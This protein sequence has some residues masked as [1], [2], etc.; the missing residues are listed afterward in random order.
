MKN[1]RSYLTSAALILLTFQ[2]F[3]QPA[4][5]K[6]SSENIETLRI[7]RIPNITSAAECYFSP[8]N[9]TLIY[10]GKEQGDSN[11][12]VY[13]INIDGTN[14]KKINK[15]EGSDACSYFNPDGNSLIWTSTKDNLDLPAGNYSDPKDYPQGAEIYT[16]D[17]EGKNVVRLTNNKVYDAE[18]TYAPDGHKILFGRQI[19]GKMDL[20]TMDKDGSH[21][22]QI[23][24][25]PNWQ[26]G[27]AVYLPDNKTIIIRAWKKSEEG[28]KSRS[29]QLFTL[30][31][32]GSNLKQITFEEGIH[33]APAPAPDGI[34]VIYVKLLPPHNFELF[35]LNLQTLEE[36][37]LTFNDA[38]DGFPTFS[39]DGKTVAFSSGRGANPGERTLS[40]YLLDISSLHLGK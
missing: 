17:L 6:D 11:Y 37:R 4:P 26:E 23:T 39:P 22:T 20:W 30:N 21:Q 13:T 34:H 27:G 9:K 25:T 35:L 33:W 31:E 14:R 12:K 36:K 5:V 7:W 3:G 28:N 15:A 18:V 8:D 1:S 38:F 2:V 16:S 29:M 10:D 19:D 32:D 24:F 40:L